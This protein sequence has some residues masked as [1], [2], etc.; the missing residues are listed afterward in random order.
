MRR[1]FMD[2][3]NEFSCCYSCEIQPFMCPGVIFSVIMGICEEFVST[4]L[5][6]YAHQWRAKGLRARCWDLVHL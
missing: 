2:I 4:A 6:K 5:F 1:H 3:R